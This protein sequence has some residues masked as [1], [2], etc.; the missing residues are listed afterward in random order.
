MDGRLYTCV[1]ILFVYVWKS[2]YVF[3]FY[4][5]KCVCDG[6]K[7][8]ARLIYLSNFGTS[9]ESAAIFR[10]T[11]GKERKRNDASSIAFLGS[12]YFSD[13]FLSYLNL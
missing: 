8:S 1:L 4:T 6:R 9:S 3:I 10:A 5:Y 7:I 13:A 11:R 12:A 2:V